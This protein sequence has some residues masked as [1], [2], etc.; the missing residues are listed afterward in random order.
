MDKAVSGG[1]KGVKLQKLEDSYWEDTS[2]KVI[3]EK[4]PNA[5]ILISKQ[6]FK[7]PKTWK[8][9]DDVSNIVEKYSH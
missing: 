4:Y 9:Y 6:D 2:W 1:L 7:R 8:K 5:K 3:K